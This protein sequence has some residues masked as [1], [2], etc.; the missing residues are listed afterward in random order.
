MVSKQAKISIPQK[1]KELAEETAKKLH[2]SNTTAYI[3]HLIRT[4]C[5]GAK[6]ENKF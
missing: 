1:E 6:E 3:R 4:N 5:A 2:Y